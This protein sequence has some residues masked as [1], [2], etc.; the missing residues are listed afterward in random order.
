MTASQALPLAGA[1]VAMAGINLPSRRRG[2]SRRPSWRSGFD[3]AV[4][5]AVALA[6][7]R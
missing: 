7:P 3:P 2:R 1:V 5:E 4:S 6:A